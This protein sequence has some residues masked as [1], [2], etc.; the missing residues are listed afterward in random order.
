[1]KSNCKFIHLISILVLAFFVA[2]PYADAQRMGHGASRGSMGGGARPSGGSYGGSR[3][4]SS[5]SYSGS[6]SSMNG[7]S[8]KSSQ[9]RP[10]SSS[11]YNRPS[12]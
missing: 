7:G 1:M 12:T 6:R 3:P 9:S 8:V 10:S 5:S 2:L 11:T 4:S